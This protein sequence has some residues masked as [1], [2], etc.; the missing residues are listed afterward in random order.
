MPSAPIPVE[1]Y[2]ISGNC[3][4]P[5][6]IVNERRSRIPDHPALRYL[7]VRELFMWTVAERVSPGGSIS[8]FHDLCQSC[9]RMSATSSS[10]LKLAQQPSS[11]SAVSSTLSNLPV[12]SLYVVTP[13]PV[14]ESILMGINDS[15]LIFH[16]SAEYSLSSCMRVKTAP[17][18]RN[19]QRHRLAIMEATTLT[20]V[21]S[22]STTITLSC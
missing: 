13:C 22:T 15:F 19:S 20:L 6:C 11:V 9:I 10:W 7:I 5:P 14:A 1:R 12:L 3:Y 4:T 17:R 8:P 2:Q 18:G 21:A 16:A